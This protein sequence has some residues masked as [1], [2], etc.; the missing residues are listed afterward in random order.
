[1]KVECKAEVRLV[2]TSVGEVDS[3]EDIVDAPTAKQRFHDMLMEEVSGDTAIEISHYA[4]SKKVL[5]E[6]EES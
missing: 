5:K 4:L 1:M 2:I 6:T 3:L